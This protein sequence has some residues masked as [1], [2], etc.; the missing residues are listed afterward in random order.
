[1]NPQNLTKNEVQSVER[2]LDKFR[3]LDPDV[4][5]SKYLCE[6]IDLVQEYC[7]KLIN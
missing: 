1:M 3:T 4:E 5:N 6:E 7:M 2:I